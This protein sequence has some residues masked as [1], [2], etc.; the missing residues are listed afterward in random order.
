MKSN[1]VMASV[2][3]M[4]CTRTQTVTTLRPR[5][6]SDRATGELADGGTIELRATDTPGG[7]RWQADKTGELVDSATLRSYRTVSHLDGAVTGLLLGV[8]G[9]GAIGATAGLLQGDDPNSFISQTDA[10]AI[11][12][13]LLGG[14]GGVIGLTAGAVSGN[15]HVYRLESSRV[16]QIL[17]MVAPGAAGAAVSWSF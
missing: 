7:L 10:M 1:V 6:A 17:P 3:L 2:V 11:Y 12:G 16:P 8:L 15:D 9:G 14:L 4:G 13:V 5:S